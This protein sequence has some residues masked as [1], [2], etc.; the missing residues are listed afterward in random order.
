MAVR[1]LGVAES[2]GADAAT[3]GYVDSKLTGNVKAAT[4]SIA[5][6][7]IT[8]ISDI[9]ISIPSAGDYTFQMYIPIITTGT[10]STVTLNIS[11]S[12][13][14]TTSVREFN[15]YRATSGSTVSHVVRFNTF[16]SNQTVLSG[17][18]AGTY[19][20]E[21]LGSIV[22]STSGLISLSGTLTGTSVTATVQTGA[23]IK[24]E[25]VV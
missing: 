24:V 3:K 11:P 1:Q 15:I 4:T 23:F 13:A 10:A 6:G 16:S 9:S 7:S 19:L 14:P 22:A 2:N 18:A 17:V 8:A 20:I 5:N 21:V 12:G 25:R